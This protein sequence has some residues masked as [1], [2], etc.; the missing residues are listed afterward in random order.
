MPLAQGMMIMDRLNVYNTSTAV[1]ITEAPPYTCGETLHFNVSVENITTPSHLPTPTGGTVQIYDLNSQTILGTGTL[2]S[3][4]VTIP[5]ILGIGAFS[6]VAQYLGTSSAPIFDPSTSPTPINF[7]ISS[8]TNTTTTITAPTAN[9]YFCAGQNLSVTATVVPSTATGNVQF[10][11]YNGST[12]TLFSTVALSSGTAIATLIAG[13]LTG[14]PSGIEYWLQAVYEGAGCYNASSSPSGS[15]GKAI[16]ACANEPTDISISDVTPGTEFCWHTTFGCTVDVTSSGPTG[17]PSIGT[18][19]IYGYQLSGTY[20]TPVL[21]GSMTPTLGVA[22]FTTLNF[23]ALGT[24]EWFLQ[25]TYTDT[26]GCYDSNST[27]TGTDGYFIQTYDNTTPVSVLFAAPPNESSYHLGEVVPITIDIQ[28][29]YVGVSGGTATL[30]SSDNVFATFPTDWNVEG[31]GTPSG[32][33]VTINWNV[34]VES[35]GQLYFAVVY[36][37]NSP[38]FDSGMST[39]DGTEDT[40]TLYWNSE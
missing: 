4:A 40:Y 22:D 26:S 1:T 33:T 30:Y 14:T 35:S 6:V 11:Y 25:A 34:P 24:G 23:P 28:N 32:G 5:I 29:T 31:T 17:N 2:V 7:G 13:T 39:I 10:S 19:D 8:P 38:C 3:G 12:T 18:V 15:L 36:G 9:T 37:G 21:L 27:P 20:A 16:F